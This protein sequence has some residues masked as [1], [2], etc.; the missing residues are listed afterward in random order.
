MEGIHGSLDGLQDKKMRPKSE[1][2]GVMSPSPFHC[3]VF[4]LS[5]RQNEKGGQ[6]PKES[7]VPRGDEVCLVIKSGP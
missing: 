5:P 7:S 1:P 4:S 6:G 2:W 3:R